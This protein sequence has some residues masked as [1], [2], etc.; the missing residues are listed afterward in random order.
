MMVIFGIRRKNIFGKEKAPTGTESVI[1]LK[2]SYICR[3]FLFLFPFKL[4]YN[5]KWKSGLVSLR[6]PGTWERKVCK[7]PLNVTLYFNE[8]KLNGT[9]LK[10]GWGETPMSVP[11]KWWMW[12][13][14]SGTIWLVKSLLG[15]DSLSLYWK[16]YNNRYISFC[17]KIKRRRFQNT[18]TKVL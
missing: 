14:L 16:F 11:Q 15:G 2:Q 1:G 10:L 12:E 3:S 6:E 18:V 7:Q 8:A 5:T 9:E 17:D 4:R 13:K